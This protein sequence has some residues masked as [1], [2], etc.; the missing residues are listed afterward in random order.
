[1][2]DVPQGPV[3]VPVLFYLSDFA[4]VCN[5]AGGTMFHAYDNDL[6]NLI[7]RL[8]HTSFSAIEWLKTS[9]IKLNK[10]KCQLLVSRHIYE[11]ISVKMWDKKLW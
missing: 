5:F 2:K 9:N 7:K 11:N 4:E 1:M 3:L 6:N 10:D 8:E